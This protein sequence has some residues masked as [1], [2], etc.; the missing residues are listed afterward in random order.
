MCF[1]VLWEGRFFAGE[2]EAF[3]WA[4][5]EIIT[6]YDEETTALLVARLNNQYYEETVL[7]SSGALSFS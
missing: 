3:V 1:V 7:R 4:G 5:L 6:C 2:A